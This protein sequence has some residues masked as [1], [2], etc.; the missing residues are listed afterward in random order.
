MSE[1]K[2]LAKREFQ[3]YE[4]D[5]F[6]SV[7]DALPE[8]VYELSENLSGLEARTV[9]ETRSGEF[10]DKAGFRYQLWVTE[11]EGQKV[12]RILP[13]Q[14]NS[15]GQPLGNATTL[16]TKWYPF[17]KYSELDE[18]INNG[19]VRTHDSEGKDKMVTG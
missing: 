11:R 19:V 10:H 14:I 9:N 15:N 13:L 12:A 8:A 16:S 4:I 7:V 1:N 5:N 17:G 18:L 6:G 3:I 2:D